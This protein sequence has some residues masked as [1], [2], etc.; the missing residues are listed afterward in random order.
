MGRYNWEAPF[1][2]FRSTLAQVDSL[3]RYRPMFDE[4][5]WHTDKKNNKIK[6]KLSRL[7]SKKSAKDEEEANEA[8]MAIIQDV[9]R[10]VSQRSFDY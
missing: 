5:R 9:Q 7:L 1:S 10:M 2:I 3:G 4:K 8:A 6:E